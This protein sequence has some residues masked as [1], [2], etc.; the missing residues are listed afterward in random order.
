VKQLFDAWEHATI[1]VDCEPIGTIAQTDYGWCYL[2]DGRVV[3]YWSDR[4]GAIDHLRDA[5]RK[6]R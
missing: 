6:G 1:Y 2:R 5:A 4:Q 3:G